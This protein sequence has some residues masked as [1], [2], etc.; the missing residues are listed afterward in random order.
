MTDVTAMGVVSLAERLVG[1]GQFAIITSSPPSVLRLSG[2]AV[3][4]SDDDDLAVLEVPLDVLL[5][6]TAGLEGV[7]R[8]R[9]LS[10][11]RLFCS[12][13]PSVGVAGGLRATTCLRWRHEMWRRFS[14]PTSDSGVCCY[15]DQSRDDDPFPLLGEIAAG[16]HVSTVIELPARELYGQV[17]PALRVCVVVL[18]VVEPPRAVFISVPLRADVE[19]VLGEFESLASQG[20]RT[21]HGFALDEPIDPRLGLLPDQRD[22]ERARRI[23][24]ASAIGELRRLADLYEIGRPS[25][26][27]VKPRHQPDAGD[28]PLLTP[29]MIRSG[30]IVVDELNRWVESSAGPPLQ[31]GDVVISAI[32]RP[33][34]SIQAAE[35]YGDDLPMIASHNVLVLKTGSKLPPTERRLLVHFI[36]SRRFAEQLVSDQQ[37][38]MRILAR[39]LADVRVPVPD[40]DLLNAFQAVESASADFE[41]WRD[42][43]AALLEASLDSDDLQE[44]RTS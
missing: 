29:R 42:E 5:G 13:R 19:M 9:S 31:A 20:G 37:T 17:S 7:L 30:R 23:E 38:V 1:G 26:S 16:R 36:G 44:A 25:N 27:A 21:A 39:E 10:E 33:G 14:H 4:S 24:E 22:P 43:A 18:E 28:V 3:S 35:V 12:W 6:D 32:G 15:L 2:M 41:Q 8:I 34:S 11:R 40:S